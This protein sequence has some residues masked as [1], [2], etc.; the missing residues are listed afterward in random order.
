MRE[1]VTSSSERKT[2]TVL[3][4]FTTKIKTYNCARGTGKSTR[5]RG[6]VH[7]PVAKHT[8]KR[9]RNM[10]PP[11]YANVVET[12]V[13]DDIFNTTTTTTTEYVYEWK[14]SA[15]KSFEFRSEL[16]KILQ[17]FHSLYSL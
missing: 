4:W 14:K 13:L 2:R 9:T 1:R 15:G 6:R 8:A 10:Y 3:A 7:V 11:V 5:A 16:E 12:I 17:F